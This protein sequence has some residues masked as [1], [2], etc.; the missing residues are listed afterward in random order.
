MS[1]QQRE[2]LTSMTNDRVWGPVSYQNLGGAFIGWV[3]VSLVTNAVGLKGDGFN[4]LWVIQSVL[5]LVGAGVGIAV[6]IRWSG[7][8]IFDRVYYLAAFRIR[9]ATGG[10]IVTPPVSTGVVLTDSSSLTLLDAD[11]TVLARTY[12][13]EEDG[14]A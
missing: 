3:M 1:Y 8:S 6:T 11:G 12:R 13:P 9:Q 2:P 10:H 7:L 14:D 5:T 4:A